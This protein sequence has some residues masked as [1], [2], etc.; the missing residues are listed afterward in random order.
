RVFREGGGTPGW[1][2]AREVDRAVAVRR[3]G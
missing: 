3:V 2:V 1:E